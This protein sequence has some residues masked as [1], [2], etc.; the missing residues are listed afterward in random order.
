MID[1]A[2]KLSAKLQAT[3]RIGLVGMLLIYKL[4]SIPHITMK[5]LFFQTISRRYLPETKR[6]DLIRRSP[7]GAGAGRNAPQLVD[8]G[9]LGEE[10]Q[11]FYNRLA[12]HPMP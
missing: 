7:P 1:A 11:T 2:S 9:H 6:L 3:V 12:F 5:H 10:S 4:L 8:F